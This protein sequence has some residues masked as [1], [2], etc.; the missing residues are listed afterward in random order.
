[1]KLLAV[2]TGQPRPIRAKSGRTGHFKE[3]QAAG[4]I[5][6][7]GL[8]GDSIVDTAHHGGPD[9]AVYIFGEIDRLWWEDHLQRALPA[10]FFG[11][12]LLIDRLAT[13]DL[14][15]GDVLEIGEVRL[16]ITSPRI[17]CVTFA[18]RI[19]DP[20]GVKLFHEAARPGAYARVLHSG[21]VQPW[22]GVNH[23]PYEGDRIGVGENFR[24]FLSGFPDPDLLRRALQVPAHSGLHDMAR[25]RLDQT[26]S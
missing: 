9:Q 25:K 8:D 10:G 3:P 11:E 2:C 18:A 15:L 14:A 19:G 12:N 24:A 20:Q 6:P 23:L 4:H 13:D 26:G 22:D 17:P 5:G 21:D 7:D 1:M 16:Q